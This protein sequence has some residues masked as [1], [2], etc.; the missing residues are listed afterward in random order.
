[1]Y[2]PPQ[3]FQFLGAVLF[4]AAV[5]L[6]VIYIALFILFHVR[7]YFLDWWYGSKKIQWLF[8]RRRYRKQVSKIVD[9][10]CG[11]FFFSCVAYSADKDKYTDK[12]T[13]LACKIWANRFA[14]KHSDWSGKFELQNS[15]K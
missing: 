11:A 13:S 7:D 6:V 15:V 10:Y 12:F 8:L 3:F 2:P 5:A 1:M 14:G 9:Q 4:W